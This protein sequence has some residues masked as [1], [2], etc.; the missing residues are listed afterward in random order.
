MNQGPGYQFLVCGGTSM[1][2]YKNGTDMKYVVPPG[3]LRRASIYRL[4]AAHLSLRLPP[5][6]RK[7]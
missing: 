4:P 2:R 5:S 7:S 1:T 6:Y 3:S